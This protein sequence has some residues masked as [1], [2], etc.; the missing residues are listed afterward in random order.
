VNLRELIKA[1]ETEHPG[2]WGNTVYGAVA[3]IIFLAGVGIYLF[4]TRL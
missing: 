2:W 4:L 3:A 1:W